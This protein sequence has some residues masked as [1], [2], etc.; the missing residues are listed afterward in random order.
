MPRFV[1]NLE[2]RMAETLAHSPVCIQKENKEI[3]RQLSG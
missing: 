2:R 3:L 1:N